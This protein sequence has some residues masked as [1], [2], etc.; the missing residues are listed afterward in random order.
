MT[1]DRSDVLIVGA[2]ASGGVGGR[3]LAE[4]GFSVTVLEQGGWPDAAEYPAP[5]EDWEIRST[6]R[7][8]ADPNVRGL[9]GDY[10]VDSD[11]SGVVPL[12][13]NSVGGSMVQFAFEHLKAK[14]EQVALSPSS[15]GSP[16]DLL[17]TAPPMTIPTGQPPAALQPTAP[18]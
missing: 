11:D 8:S 12:M 15:D 14:K 16:I 9:P 5:R 18:A 4:A 1:D 3:R 13:Y 2:G 7:W 6:R 10:P 17:L